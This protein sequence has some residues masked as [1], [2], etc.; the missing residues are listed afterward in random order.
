ML[1]TGT[2]PLRALWR[3]ARPL[4]KPGPRCSSVAAGRS[5]ARLHAP[6]LVAPPRLAASG[7]R[8]RPGAPDED[9]PRAHRD[10][11]HDIES[12]ADAAVDEDLDLIADG[13][14]HVGQRTGCGGHRIELAAAVVGDD[15]AVDAGVRGAPRVLGIEHA[16]D[17]QPTGPLLAHPGDVVPGHAG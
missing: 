8:P 10:H 14:D 12:R 17:D 1:T 5:V 9:R 11:L 16:L 4:P 13:V 6:A 15:E 7:D 3:F 2:F